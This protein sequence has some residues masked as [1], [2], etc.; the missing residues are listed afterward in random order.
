MIA[1]LSGDI[2]KALRGKKPNNEYGANNNPIL[3]YWL[4]VGEDP[5]PDY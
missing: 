2:A 5:R 4:P 1:Y 3:D